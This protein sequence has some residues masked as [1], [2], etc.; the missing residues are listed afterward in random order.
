MEGMIFVKVVKENNIDGQ[1]NKRTIIS[2][3]TL[4]TVDK[5][6]LG[7][8]PKRYFSVIRPIKMHFSKNDAKN[9]FF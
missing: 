9:M 3:D 1:K 7:L 6:A 5:V 4:Q 2:N 8:P